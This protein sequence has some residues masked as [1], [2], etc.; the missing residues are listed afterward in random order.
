MMPSSKTMLWHRHPDPWLL[1]SPEAHQAQTADAL[2][3]G[4]LSFFILNKKTP[5]WY[6][7]INLI[8]HRCSDLMAPNRDNSATA[9]M[10]Y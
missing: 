7:T 10:G 4:D 6:I 8:Q 2:F 9:I 3:F 1:Q 5:K